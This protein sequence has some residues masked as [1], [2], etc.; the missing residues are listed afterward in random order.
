MARK[1]KVKKE[2]EK[3]SAPIF[4]VMD[5]NTEVSWGYSAD[6]A[7]KSALE[8]ALNERDNLRAALDKIKEFKTALRAFLS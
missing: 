2:K 7:M 3:G 6:G 1:I 8:T 5:G 4:V